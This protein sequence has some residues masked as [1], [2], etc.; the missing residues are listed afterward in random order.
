MEYAGTAQKL[1][2]S[3]HEAALAWQVKLPEWNREGGRFIP[4]P[5]N[6]LDGRRFE[7]EPPDTPAEAIYYPPLPEEL[8]ALPIFKAP[9]PKGEGAAAKAQARPGDPGEGHRRKNAEPSHD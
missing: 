1:P 3:R 5:A 6:Y 7:D 4:S 9:P 2:S 8:K